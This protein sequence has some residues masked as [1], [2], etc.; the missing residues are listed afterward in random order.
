MPDD[1]RLSTRYVSILICEEVN[2]H[3]KP[4]YSPGAGENIEGVVISRDKGPSNCPSQV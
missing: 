4:R 3:G 1:I 2:V